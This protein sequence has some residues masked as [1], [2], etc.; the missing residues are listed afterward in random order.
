MQLEGLTTDLSEG[1]C[2]V[3]AQRAPFSPG[4]RIL[5]EITKNG[6]SLRTEATVI[7]NLKDQIMGLRFLEMPPEQAAILARWIKAAIPLPHSR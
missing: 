5:L 1:G 7:Y 2:G 3:M 4:T 6:V